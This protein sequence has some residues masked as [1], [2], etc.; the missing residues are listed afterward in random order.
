MILSQKLIL[1]YWLL[2]VVLSPAFIL[3]QETIKSRWQVD[4]L[5]V[6]NEDRFEYHVP[7]RHMFIKQSL[8]IT[9]NNYPLNEINDYKFLDQRTIRFFPTPK[10]G[11]SLLVSYRRLPFNLKQSYSLYKKDTLRVEQGDSTKKNVR[12]VRVLPATFENP[13]DDFGSGLQKSG[14][15]MRGV[16]IG[17]NRDL[18]LNSGLNLEMS[19]QLSED[20]EIVAALTDESTPIQPEGNTQTLDEVDQVFIQFKSPYVEGTVGDLNLTYKNSRFGNLSRKLQGISVLGKFNNQMAGATVATTRGFFNRATF[21]GQEGN[22]G[23]YQLTGKNGEQQIIVLAGTER[24]WI[25]GRK[26][27]RGESN[28]YIIEYANGQVTFTNNRLVTSESR[29][30]IDFEYFPAIQKY[31]RSA[32]SGLAGGQLLENK[33]NYRVSFYQEKDNINK[34]VGEAD[35]LTKEEK[36]ILRQAGDD[37]QKAAVPGE[38]FVGA[39]K[40]NY[41]KADTTV[42]NAN[43]SIFKYVGS[44]FGDYNVSFTFVGRGKGDYVRDRLGKY[45]WVGESNTGV[46]KGDYMPLKLIPLP[47]THRFTDLSMAWKPTQNISIS[48]EYALSNLDRNSFS[49]IQNND[50]A[51]SAFSV[52]AKANKLSPELFGLKMGEL[53]ISLNSRIIDKNFQSVDRFN[54]PDFQRYWNVLQEASTN[55]AEKSVQF[56]SAYRPFTGL[57]LGIGLGNLNKESQTSNRYSATVNFDRKNLFKSDFKFES[58]T[59]DLTKLNINN[60]WQRVK[61]TL[62]RDIWKFQPQFLYEFENRRNDRKSLLSGFRYDDLGLRLGLINWE[63]FNGFVQVNERK[64]QVYDSENDGSL[65]N[66][67]VTKT[68]RIRLELQNLKET[69]ASLEIVQRK[70]DYTARFEEVKSDSVKQL[71]ADAAVQDTVWQDRKTNLAILRISHSRWKK[72]LSANLQYRIS[73]EQTALREKVYIKVAQGRG[74][75]RF[76]EDLKEYVPDPD[77]D[78]ILFIL[79]SG[80]FEPVTKLESALRLNYDA[81]RFWRKPKGLAQT[82]LSNISGSSYFRVEEETKEKDLAAIYFLDL[83][84]FQQD[85]TLRGSLIYDQDVYI[86]KRNRKLNFRLLYRYRDDSFNQFLDANENEDRQTIERGF[87]T[88]WKISALVK[89][90]SEVRQK[91][92]K[93]ESKANLTRNRDISALFVSQKIFYRPIKHW[94]FRFITDYGQEENKAPSYPIDLWFAVGKIQGNYILAGKG[95]I[96]ADFEYQSVTPTFNPK[97]L[98]VP[99]EMARGKKEGISKKWQLRAEYTVS[100]NILFTFLYSARDEAG[101]NEIIQ[102]GQAEVRAFF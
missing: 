94:E 64:Y 82:L 74:N 51:G 99:F 10:P 12:Q 52:D 88:D 8:R 84:K 30:E 98:A 69:T 5:I 47:Q 3:A 100:K 50:N 21:I 14:S 59:S 101:F 6:V 102:T 45:S 35:D 9:K 61:G 1:K 53:D 58:V 39:G 92:T 54:S 56:N 2:L 33:L 29:I 76:D 68:N 65:V 73:T 62:L 16:N 18:T 20:I 85:K 4:S 41:V 43:I 97:K 25:N 55:N 11:D 42:N 71:F 86:M 60:R 81:S 90:Q 34:A 93:R 36:S 31:S 24:V 77:G 32:I 48:S 7:P 75:L 22:Q 87:R 79:P 57:K 27:L 23:P 37:F 78:F 66:Q 63:Y 26:M 91:T 72:A 40:G 44:S 49:K 83:S 46:K 28:D 15:I 96:T 95:R 38:K 89:S 70:K 80:K 67:S 13:F 17:T 19:G